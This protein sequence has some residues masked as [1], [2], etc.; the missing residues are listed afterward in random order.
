MAASGTIIKKRLESKI[1]AKPPATDITITPVAV[2]STTL[3]GYYGYSETE[4]ATVTTVGVP[5]AFSRDTRQYYNFGLDSEGQTKMAIKADE[6]VAK[7]DK[8]TITSSN[9]TFI[10]TDIEDYPYN[11]INLAIILTLKEQVN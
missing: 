3:S 11:N 9:K 10:V 7:N 1:F 6:T 2:A 8:I 5:Y 4:S